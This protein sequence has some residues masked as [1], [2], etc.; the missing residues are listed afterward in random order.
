MK[1]LHLQY[2]KDTGIQVSEQVESLR[3]IDSLLSPFNCPEC[4]EIVSPEEEDCS[5]I[6]DYIRWLKNLIEDAQKHVKK[7]DEIVNDM[8]VL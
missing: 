7:L 6:Y 1:E 4:K 2:Q 3:G 8:R 5:E